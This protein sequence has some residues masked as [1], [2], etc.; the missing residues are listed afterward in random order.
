MLCGDGFF[1]I[2]IMECAKGLGWVVLVLC[3]VD[4]F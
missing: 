3:N 2:G 1:C 4:T